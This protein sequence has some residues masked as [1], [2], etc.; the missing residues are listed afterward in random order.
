[1]CKDCLDDD[2]ASKCGLCVW[3]WDALGIPIYCRLGFDQEKCEGPGEN[4]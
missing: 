2:F 3:G 1:M 4:E